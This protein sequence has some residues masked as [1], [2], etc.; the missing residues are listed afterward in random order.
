[1]A[2]AT[3]RT[4][5]PRTTAPVS[6]GRRRS[7]LAGHG[8]L[9]GAVSK[10]TKGTTKVG[11]GL[12][13]GVV[14][15]GGGMAKS[16]QSVASAVGTA[17]AVLGGVQESDAADDAAQRDEQ[18][19]ELFRSLKLQGGSPPEVGAIPTVLRAGGAPG[20][21]P[22]Q[23]ANYPCKKLSSLGAESLDFRG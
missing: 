8:N 15:I 13:S 17:T 10:L 18:V 2:K 23:A 12:A 6:D 3:P 19:M 21:P 7:R 20:G 14:G 4:T 11:K 5:T 9:L 1:M 16:V 22:V